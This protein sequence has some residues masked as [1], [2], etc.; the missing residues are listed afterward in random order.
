MVYKAYDDAQYSFD[1]DDGL[2]DEPQHRRV[3][4]DVSNQTSKTEMSTS[5]FLETDNSDELSF[6]DDTDYYNNVYDDAAYDDYQFYSGQ[7][8][9]NKVWHVARSCRA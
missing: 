9:Y 7:S 3:R 1:V 4:R 2:W 5:V 8:H 6:Y